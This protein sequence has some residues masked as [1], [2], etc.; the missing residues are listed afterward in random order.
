[1]AH[2]FFGFPTGWLTYRHRE[3]LPYIISLRGSDVP[4]DNPRL[5]LEYKLLGRLF[6]EIWKNAACLV[7]NSNGL[8]QRAKRFAPLLPYNVIP[9]GVDTECFTPAGNKPAMKP[10]KLLAVG[11]VTQVKRFDL[12]VRSIYL[13][14]K[15]GIDIE[16]TIAGDGNLTLQLK[17]LA[18]ELNIAPY[19]HLMDWVESEKIPAMYQNHHAFLLTSINE[20][21]NN[22]MLEAMASGL[23]IITTAC[24]GTQ[25]LVTDNGIIISDPTPE[26]IAKAIIE[27]TEDPKKYDKMAECSR[28]TAEQ[29]SWT[30]S[31]EEYLQLYKRI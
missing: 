21:M 17:Q 20:G 13:A 25:E 9:N 4:G 18:K 23:P 16:L 1:M 6:H 10:F 30:H 22:A 24:E 11:R 31:A 7:T 14:R 15:T 12:A 8:A 27:T 5:R 19:I 29:F 26:N 2:A 28:R 3:K